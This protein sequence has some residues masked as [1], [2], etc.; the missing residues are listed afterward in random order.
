[1]NSKILIILTLVSTS[2][3]SMEQVGLAQMRVRYSY[4]IMANNYLTHEFTGQDYLELHQEF[5]VYVPNS[6]PANTLANKFEI[7]IVIAKR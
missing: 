2:L 4:N 7:L 1:M 6:Q 5:E 3:N